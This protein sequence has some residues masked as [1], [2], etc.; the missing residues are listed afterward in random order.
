MPGRLLS[1]R[2][3]TA[4][5]EELANVKNPEKLMMAH[6]EKRRGSPITIE[7]LKES[8]ILR[9][10]ML[11]ETGRLGKNDLIVENGCGKGE[12]IKSLREDGYAAVGLDIVR[13]EKMPPSSFIRAN[14][15][16][17]PFKDNKVKL[18]VD[19]FGLGYTDID[20]ATKEMW[21]VLAPGGKA[22]IMLHHPDKME[23]AMEEL[24]GPFGIRRAD[25][26][27]Y[28]GENPG[29]FVRNYYPVSRWIVNAFEKKE[30]AKRF[31]EGKG[32]K[33]PFIGEDFITPK[34]GGKI[35]LTYCLILEK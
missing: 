23:A 32:F 20:E 17:L 6:W 11:A 29:I 30:A 5:R 3:I 26:D 12:L 22:L 21:R 8:I 34:K 9:A 7:E 10:K 13:H 24:L 19:A 27:R 4:L 25:F 31:F 18:F 15:E 33:V 35:G 14:L 28:I 1:A 16:K 2:T